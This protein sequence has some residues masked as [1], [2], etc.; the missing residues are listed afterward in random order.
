MVFWTTNFKENKNMNFIIGQIVER[1][2][3]EENLERMVDGRNNP[4]LFADLEFWKKDG[5]EYILE[6]LSEKNYAVCY[7]MKR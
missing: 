5:T 4:I 1:K 6:R 7:F 3:I 2:V